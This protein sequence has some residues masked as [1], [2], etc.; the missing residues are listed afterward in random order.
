MI[1]RHLG[2]GGSAGVRHLGVGEGHPRLG[3]APHQA[4]AVRAVEV[5]H[6]T[7]AQIGGREYGLIDIV[8]LEHKI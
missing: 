3:R 8:I 6:W 4:R 2:H 1:A 7:S 5:G